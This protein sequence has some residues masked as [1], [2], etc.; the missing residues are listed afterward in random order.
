MLLVGFLGVL[1][2]VFT[3]GIFRSIFHVEVL[4]FN[5]ALFD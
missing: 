2:A 3:G 5:G 1:L 4:D